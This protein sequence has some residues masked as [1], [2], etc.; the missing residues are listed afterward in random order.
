MPI[1]REVF[2]ASTYEQQNQPKYVSTTYQMFPY[3]HSVV[4]DSSGG[5]FTITLPPVSECRG[6]SY[7][8]SFGGSGTNDV[9]IIDKANDAGYSDQ[10]ID[11]VGEHLL[12]Q[13]NGER[14]SEP[15]ITE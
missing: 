1:I 5:I 11:A 6:M 13:C 15:K 10:T 12:L 4:T 3:D 9:T 8:I 14:W 2:E 7:L